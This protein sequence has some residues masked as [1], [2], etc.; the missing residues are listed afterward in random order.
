MEE[1]IMQAEAVLSLKRMLFKS[2]R[3]TKADFEKAE[4]S[5]NQLLIDRDLAVLKVSKDIRSVVSNSP[6]VSK[7]YRIPAAMVMPFSEIPELKKHIPVQKVANYEELQAELTAEAKRLTDEQAMVSNRIVA[8]Y[9]ED[10]T[11]NVKGLMSEAIG[12][13]GNIEDVFD[14]KK[15]LERNG[16]MKVE[17]AKVENTEESKAFMESKI[18]L[19]SKRKQVKDQIYKLQKKIDNPTQHVKFD[20][21]ELKMVVWEK[22][23]MVLESEL[24]QIN[25]EIATK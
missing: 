21:V 23:L 12:L 1:K 24:A 16:F 5:L 10:R 22:E 25:L 8:S 15:F 4:D 6:A 20:R 3:C 9:R 13:R 11:L 7:E 14:K 18:L 17:I 2:N 19:S